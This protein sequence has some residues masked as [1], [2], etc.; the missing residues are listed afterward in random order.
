MTTNRRRIRSGSIIL[1]AVSAAVGIFILEGATHLWLT[2]FA[3]AEQLRVYGTFEQNRRQFENEATKSASR[4]AAARE[5]ALLT[6]KITPQTTSYLNRPEFY[7]AIAEQNRMLA[8]MGQRYA[9]PVYDFASVFPDEA[10]YLRRCGP[11]E[12]GGRAASGGDRGETLVGR[13]ACGE[14]ENGGGSARREM[15]RGRE[16]S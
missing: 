14:S 16:S 9:V 4:T 6:F 8:E 13:R 12:R 7:A 1:A 11:R 2:H 5:V 3:S 15:S 10:Q